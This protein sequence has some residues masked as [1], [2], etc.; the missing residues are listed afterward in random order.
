MPQDTTHTFEFG[1]VMAGAISA[2]AYTAGVV[3]FLIEALDGWQAAKDDPATAVPRHAV[4]LRAMSG[5]SAGAMTVAMAAAALFSELSPV[6]DPEN[7]PPPERN[8]LYDCWVRQIDIT[9]LLSVADIARTG[10]AI[11][12][13]DS[14]VL[15]KIGQLALSTRPNAAVRPYVGDPLAAFLT[16]ANLRGVPYGFK[17][18]GAETQVFGLSNHMDDVRF[19]I[20]PQRCEEVEGMDC[21]D[22]DALFDGSERRADWD[23]LA[24]AALA[25]GAFP[26]G[27]QPR[28]I[29]RPTT[30]YE[31]V[32]YGRIRDR[33]DWGATPPGDRYTCLCVDGGLM[34]NEP[35]G[36]ARAYLAGGA[37]KRNPRDA[38]EASRAMIL[39]DPFP[40]TAD[41]DPDY[42]PNDDL[43]AVA[44]KMFGALKSQARFAAEDLELAADPKVFSRFAITPARYDAA[45]NAAEPAIAS[46]VMGGFGGFFKEDFR[47]H[48]FHLGR[49]NCQ[50]FLARYFCLPESNP[51]F[52]AVP[53]SVRDAWYVCERDGSRKTIDVQKRDG[54]PGEMET[55]PVLPIIPLVKP[56]DA[57]IA[58]PTWPARPQ[59]PWPDLEARV[60][61][62][63]DAL[64]RTIIDTQLENVFGSAMRWA[65][66]SAWRLRLS[67]QV[68]QSLMRLIAEE[69]QMIDGGR[70]RSR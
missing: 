51:L 59:F 4:K 17:L 22:P 28:V 68:T 63:V 8:R 9:E 64:G 35:L 57:E 45:G 26:V 47:R 1:L 52:D 37:D 10:R 46:A 38:T 15:G 66:R 13:L 44:G 55:R 58:S 67:R 70:A 50:N 39:V 41:F 29:E 19:A 30:D 65:L 23:R 16:V 20:S 43:I 34:N 3:D 61:S 11:S 69:M 33:P 42:K 62:R 24:L 56:V 7:P 53:Q 18:F 36:L 2:G 48:D 32:A 49:R 40:N 6:R 54:A 27:L 21:L 25:S 14:T 60:A 5:A 31:P 12:L